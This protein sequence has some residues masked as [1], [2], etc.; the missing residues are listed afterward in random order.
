M[1]RSRLRLLFVTP[2]VVLP[3]THRTFLPAVSAF[4]W[5]ASIVTGCSAS[6]EAADSSAMGSGGT[7][8]GGSGGQSATTLAFG[9][10]ALL[11]LPGET[12]DLTVVAMPAGSY[13][14]EFALLGDDI[15]DA[16]LDRGSAATDAAGAGVVRITAPTRPAAFTL[17][18]SIGTLAS[19]E[20]PVSVGAAGFA[21]LQVTPSYAGSRPVSTWT[22][23]IRTGQSCSEL[24][25][26]PPP[27]G[28]LADEAISGQAPRIE[29]VPVGPVLAV[30]LR[31]G[32]YVSGCLDVESLISGELNTVVVPVVD[33]PMLLAETSLDVELGIDAAAPGWSSAV[34]AA[35][36]RTAEAMIGGAPDD[37]SALL[38]AMK[39]ST[40]LPD[41][42]QLFAAARAE[43]D[44]DSA[45]SGTL[46]T[47]ESA[48]L[49]RDWVR[50]FIHTGAAALATPS[51]LSARL[52]AA[53]EA[54]GHAYLTLETVAGLPVEDS[55]VM[56]EN[57][58]TWTADPGDTVHLGATLH[59]FESRLF[60]GL[61]AAPAAQAVP[62]TTTVPG[63]LAESLSCT[64][65]AATLTGAP[66]PAY[67]GCE[68]SCV[69]ALC[70]S[71]LTAMWQRA[72]DASGTVSP[73]STL[74]I[75]AAG[76]AAVDDEARPSAFDGQWVGTLE[77]GTAAESLSGSV[78][79]VPS[80]VQ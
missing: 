59:W 64:T 56:A 17:R 40:P 77:D 73:A 33:R 57:L 15:A 22:A 69:E 67:D 71:A 79:G 60:T 28:E 80:V 76:A 23:S 11:L 7:S 39:V 68:A 37:V 1:L 32:H 75:T 3:L 52:V 74:E 2:S 29:N 19:T 18:A 8:G 41:A 70:K 42:A 4:A 66:G 24:V 36:E 12:R 26:S 54:P 25:G 46:G 14:V 16:A 50:G 51:A 63:A 48:T 31:A 20:L 58:V 5:L 47:A 38:D 27:D 21:T 6:G 34:D 13:V 78:V 65:V 53:G 35:V 30:T 44:W 55:G 62:G 9:T 49:I 45:L 10:D 43:G 61:A 72:V